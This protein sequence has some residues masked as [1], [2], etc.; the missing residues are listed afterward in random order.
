MR[1]ERLGPLPAAFAPSA[2]SFTGPGFTVAELRNG[3]AAGLWDANPDLGDVRLAYFVLS[4]HLGNLFVILFYG[5]ASGAPKALAGLHF[6]C[7][8][9]VK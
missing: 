7:G 8:G 4:G 3:P 1:L 5:P 6:F 9:S 2:L